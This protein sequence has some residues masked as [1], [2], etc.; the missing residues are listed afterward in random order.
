MSSPIFKVSILSIFP[1]IFPGP[2]EYSLAGQALKAGIW[3]YELVDIR[4]FGLTK[5][6]NVDDIPYGGGNGM[7]MRADVLGAAIDHALTLNPDATIIYMSPRGKKLTQAISQEISQSKNIIILC[8]RFEGI[9]ERIIEEYNIQEL[10]IGDYVLSGGE[11]AALV[12]LDS[13]IRLLP[14]VLENQETLCE[15]SFS[16]IGP[17]QKTLLE[18]PLYTRPAEWKGR[19]VPD[20]LVSGDHKKIEDW[21]YKKSLEIT[22]QRRPDLLK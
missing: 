14:G 22:K 12:L 20:I 9:D 18:Y 19:K 5:H 1:E 15:E 8:G 3:Q 2:L 6:K 7:V 13:C 11:L 21:R 16:I 10:S 4:D 17:A